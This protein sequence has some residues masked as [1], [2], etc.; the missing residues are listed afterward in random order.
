[1][2]GGSMMKKPGINLVEARKF[3][4]QTLTIFPHPPKLLKASLGDVGG[5]YGALAYIKQKQE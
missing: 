3:F 5:I 1:V 2:L 4:A